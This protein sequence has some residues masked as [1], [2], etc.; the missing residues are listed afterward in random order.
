MPDDVGLLNH[1][2]AVERLRGDGSA[3]AVA[4]RLFYLETAEPPAA[5]RALLPA[6]MQRALVRAARLLA[7]R[8]GR[9]HAR[10]RIDAFRS[11]YLLADRR[12]HRA[13]RTALGLPAGDMVYP[14][15]A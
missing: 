1:A 7:P 5:L 3:A 2:H 8:A 4:L 10:L 9:L 13:D 12:F 15:G 6:E 14:P 11:R